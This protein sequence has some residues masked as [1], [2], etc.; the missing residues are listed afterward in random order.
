MI[1]TTG[2]VVLEADWDGF[3]PSYCTAIK[4]DDSVVIDGA[5]LVIASDGMAGRG[6]S[7]DGN[8][9][10]SSGDVSILSSGDG[11]TYTNAL[12]ETDAFHGPCIK[13]DGNLT[14]LGGAITLYH[15]GDAGRGISVDGDLN[16][17]E[18]GF[19]PIL[20]I[21]TEGLRV[22]TGDGEFTEAKAVRVENNITISGG[23]ITID[24]VDDGLK[25]L[26]EIRI[27]SGV[28]QIV[29]SKEGIEAPFIYIEGGDIDVL[30]RDDGINATTGTNV[31]T[32]DGSI[33]EINGGWVRVGSIIGDSIDS[34]GRV[35][36]NGGTL[37]VH[38]PG[39]PP[40]TGL[41]INGPLIFNGGFI[42]VA[43]INSTQVVSPSEDSVQ[44]SVLLRRDD[45]LPVGTLFHIED[46]NGTPLVTFR[47]DR[48]YSALHVS[49]PELTQG[50]TYHVF[51]GGSSSGT[52]RGGLFTGG[53]YTPGTLRAT[54]TSDGT[55][56]TIEF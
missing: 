51:T 24:S 49:S 44:R 48:R 45:R 42:V 33:L 39:T 37:L 5:S 4:C 43:Q 53:E 7:C 2:D 18:V 41:D 12:G 50:E 10:I 38:G 56:Q 11:N 55:V 35:I 23:D 34:N 19:P 46:S 1:N 26:N 32:D 25:S 21:T 40:E 16:I 30:A 47:P 28:I 52:E 13:A 14:I 36:V 29:D 20:D 17:G 27:T 8:I 22:P 54:F 9:S 15:V 6:I 3:D 31:Q